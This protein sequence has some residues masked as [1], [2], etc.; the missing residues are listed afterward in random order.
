MEPFLTQRKIYYFLRKGLHTYD[1]TF[2]TEA[3]DNLN[4]SNFNYS[5]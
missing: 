3:V 5:R 4:S 2:T 1:S